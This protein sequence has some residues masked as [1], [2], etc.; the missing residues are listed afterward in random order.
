LPRNQKKSNFDIV[1]ED[2]DDDDDDEKKKDETDDSDKMNENV[3][4]MRERRFREFA[5]VVYN[6]EIY[7]V[8]LRHRKRNHR[9]RLICLDTS[10]F[11]GISHFRTTTT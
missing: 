11:P 1:H 8:S 7:M 10:R 2:D 4:N 9:I 6:E 3:S 5:S